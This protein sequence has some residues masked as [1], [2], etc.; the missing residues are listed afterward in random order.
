MSDI[1]IRLHIIETINRA[2]R[3]L[4]GVNLANINITTRNEI[5]ASVNNVLREAYIQLIILNNKKNQYCNATKEY[6]IRI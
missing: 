5:R 3:V 6:M 4:N 2:N 1:D